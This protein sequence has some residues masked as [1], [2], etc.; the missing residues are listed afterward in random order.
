[1]SLRSADDD[2]TTDVDSV[3]CHVESVLYLIDVAYPESRRFT[4]P[5][6]RVRPCADQRGFFLS[7]SPVPPSGCETGTRVAS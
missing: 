1:M 7:G 6:T 5:E 4:P 2:P 3:E